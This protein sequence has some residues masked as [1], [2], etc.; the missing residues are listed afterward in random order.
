MGLKC[1]GVINVNLGKQPSIYNRWEQEWLT[2][3]GTKL[4][5]QTPT[6]WWAISAQ[7]P[8]SVLICLH[9]LWHKQ[10]QC[11]RCWM[12]CQ[13]RTMQNQEVDGIVWWGLAVTSATNPTYLMSKGDWRR[14]KG[15]YWCMSSGCT[16]VPFW[17]AMQ[18]MIDSCIAQGGE[19]WEACFWLVLII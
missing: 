13:C 4:S 12:N 10:K 14:I 11:A 18:H 3:G 5:Y 16:L 7:P 19:T 2:T 17:N 9:I 15:K 1:V 6:G 8:A